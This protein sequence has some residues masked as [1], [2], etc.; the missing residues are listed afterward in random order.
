MQTLRFSLLARLAVA[1]SVAQSP[2]TSWHLIGKNSEERRER[3]SQSLLDGFQLPLPIRRPVNLA[4]VIND[5]SRS[6]VGPG[7]T[8]ALG[9]GNGANQE[10]WNGKANMLEVLA[11][12]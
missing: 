7:M 8:L 5:P 3:A 4:F 2:I 12:T 10:E 1:H 11:S 6:R 9:I